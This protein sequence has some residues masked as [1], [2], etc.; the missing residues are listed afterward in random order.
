MSEEQYDELFTHVAGKCG[1]IK[2][3]LDTF[4]SFLERKTDFY[5]QF[6]R[7]K[8][9]KYSM[10]F[11][12]G[13]A[14]GMLLQSFRQY[15]Y[16]N[17][18]DIMGAGDKSTDTGAGAGSGS[19]AG[20][21]SSTS[22]PKIT[23]K[24][25]V[26]SVRATTKPSLSAKQLAS[27]AEDAPSPG[28]RTKAGTADTA[29]TATTIPK[30][31]GVVGSLGTPI[32]PT[33]TAPTPAPT[34]TAEGKQVPV[35]NG[36]FAPGY[37]W[38][39]TLK[40]VTIYVDCPPGTRSRDVK[41]TIKAQSLSVTVSTAATAATTAVP[42]DTAVAG[43]PVLTLGAVSTGPPPAPAPTAPV[44]MGSLEDV[45][46]TEESMW[47]IASGGSGSGGKGGMDDS[48]IVITLEKTR[49]TWWKHV[50]EGHPEIDTTKVDSSQNISEYDETTQATIRKI[51][52]DQ[53]QKVGGYY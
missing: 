3:L 51:M 18:E 45:V 10:G 16:K 47:T 21:G 33:P 46:R 23:T 31:Q 36:G 52:F 41:C 25:S 17:Y 24:Q 39:Q 7:E 14:E 22:S 44:I 37:Y 50:I 38:T 2:P 4:F 19:G 12:K 48:Q 1:G 30:G 29:A 32:T 20:A 8:G 13:A 53:K 9:A 15:P 35:G 26:G 11:P 43:A 5:V 28:A 34:H 49:K 42:V 27:L 40:E 6:D